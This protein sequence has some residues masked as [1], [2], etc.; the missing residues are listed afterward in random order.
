MTLPAARKVSTMGSRLVV[1]RSLVP[2]NVEP[3]SLL[4]DLRDEKRVFLLPEM[5][6]ELEDTANFH[7]EAYAELKMRQALSRNELI[8]GFLEWAL[9][10]FWDDKGGRPKNVADRKKKVVAFAEQLKQRL[11]ERK[12][13]AEDISQNR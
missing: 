6:A 11:A 4:P 9:K 5:W 13:Q 8:E 7:S 3:P 1:P 2:P 10:S 12:A